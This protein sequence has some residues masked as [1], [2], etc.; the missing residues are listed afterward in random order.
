MNVLKNTNQKLTKAKNN[1]YAKYYPMIYALEVKT[2]EDC[3]G[4]STQVPF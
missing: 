1:Y 2:L 3:S 4:R